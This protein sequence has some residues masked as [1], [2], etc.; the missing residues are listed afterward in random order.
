MAQEGG[1]QV[2]PYGVTIQQAIVGGGLAHM[3]SVAAAAEA[4]LKQYGDVRRAVTF[5]H[6][7]IV[8]LEQK[9]K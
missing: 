6:V 4:H 3:K 7:E 1:G 5:L 2:P 8:K 9:H